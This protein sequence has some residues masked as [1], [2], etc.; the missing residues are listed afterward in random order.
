[1]EEGQPLKNSSKPSSHVGAGYISA[2]LYELLGSAPGLVHVHQLRNVAS[3]FT[4]LGLSFL[5]YKMGSRTVHA[6]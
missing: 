1:M 3:C 2:S 4:V 5:I 6:S